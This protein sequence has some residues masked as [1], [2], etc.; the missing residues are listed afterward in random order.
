MYALTAAEKGVVCNKDLQVRQPEE[1]RAC[2]GTA[3]L[4]VQ[5]EAAYFLFSHVLLTHSF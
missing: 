4:P 2:M 3:G 1:F 5:F